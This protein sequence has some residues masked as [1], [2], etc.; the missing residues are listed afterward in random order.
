LAPKWSAPVFGEKKQNGTNRKTTMGKLLFHKLQPLSCFLYRAQHIR[1][2]TTQTQVEIQRWF[3]TMNKKEHIE[4]TAEVDV[5]KFNDA[6]AHVTI[7]I[8]DPVSGKRLL[9]Q[10]IGMPSLSF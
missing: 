9:D 3:V 1:F 8:K 5:K 6:N 10:C 2:Y 4:M 7:G